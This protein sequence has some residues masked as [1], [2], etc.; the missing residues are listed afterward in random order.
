[1]TFNWEY[2][3]IDEIINNKLKDF[4][5]KRVFDSHAHLYRLSDLNINENTFLSEGPKESG[6]NVWK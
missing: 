1:M 4:L 5:P 2:S 6:F 3:S